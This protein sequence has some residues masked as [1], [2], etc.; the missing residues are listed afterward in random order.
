M[1]TETE[2]NKKLSSLLFR[3]HHYHQCLKFKSW[4]INIYMTP[5]Y[6]DTFQYHYN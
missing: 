1:D 5:W 4:Y 3:F 2:T 6:L